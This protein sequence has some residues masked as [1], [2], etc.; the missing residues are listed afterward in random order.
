MLEHQRKWVGKGQLS[1]PVGK[2]T[3]TP[4]FGTLR[5][6][7][8]ED[9]E[10]IVQT[11]ASTVY[12]KFNPIC[13][14]QICWNLHNCKQTVAVTKC[15][16]EYLYIFL[17]IFHQPLSCSR[18]VIIAGLQQVRPWHREEGKVHGDTLGDAD[19][20]L[21]SVLGNQRERGH[22]NCVPSGKSLLLVLGS[23]RRRGGGGV[24]EEE[25]NDF[26]DTVK[27]NKI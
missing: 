11:S 12:C 17:L 7:L 25:S 26:R 4:S 5:K 19:R 3:H 15:H 6:R 16:A 8:W 10:H 27:L 21:E 9:F 18:F 1:L 22:I 14:W 2:S 13:E 20:R 24:L 23:Y